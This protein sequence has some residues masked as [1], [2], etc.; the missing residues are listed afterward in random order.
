LYLGFI[1][2]FVGGQQPNQAT[3][4]GSNVLHGEIH[5]MPTASKSRQPDRQNRM[6]VEEW[7]SFDHNAPPSDL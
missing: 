7:R 3:T 1:D 4:V 2:V 5:I 6:R